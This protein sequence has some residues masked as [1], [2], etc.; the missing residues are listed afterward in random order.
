METDCEAWQPDNT[1]E[2]GTSSKKRKRARR[3]ETLQLTIAQIFIFP[4]ANYPP[5][6][7]TT[8]F[9][10]CVCVWIMQ[11]IQHGTMQTW[12]VQMYLRMSHVMC[13]ASQ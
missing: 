6:F 7:L 3:K 4:V 11:W 2:I 1:Q 5:R 12:T 8:D 13:V 9:L 10:E